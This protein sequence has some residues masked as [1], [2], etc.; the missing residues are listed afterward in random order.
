[1]LVKIGVTGK[2]L[3]RVELD[4]HV[5]DLLLL[6]LHPSVHLVAQVLCS[7]ALRQPAAPLLVRLVAAC[8]LPGTLS[9]ERRASLVF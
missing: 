5:V 2:I 1:M 7:L 3:V 4:E 6:L 9:D 8:H